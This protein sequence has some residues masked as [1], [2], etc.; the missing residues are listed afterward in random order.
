MKK[1]IP[2]IEETHSRVESLRIDANITTEQIQ[3]FI[4]KDY[5]VWATTLRHAPGTDESRRAE[6]EPDWTPDC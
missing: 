4:D 1:E 5:D 3:A 6:D 2:V